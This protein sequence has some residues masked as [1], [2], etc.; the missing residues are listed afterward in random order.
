M[1]AAGGDTPLGRGAEFDLIRAMRERWGE[2]AV[3]IGDD[4]A[5]LRPARGEQLI[6]T[7]DASIENVHFRREWLT[8]EEIGYRAV[9]AALSD[10]A[11]MAAIPSGILIALAITDDTRACIGDIADGIGAAARASGAMILGGNVARSAQFSITTTALG[12]AFTPLTRSGARP[13]DLLYVTGTLGGPAAA[14]RAWKAGVAPAPDV[15]A[16]FARPAARIR[17]ARWLAA[18]GGVAAID[19]SDGLGGDVGH[20]AAASDVTIEV[21]LERVPCWPQATEEDAIGGGEEFELLVL[22][23]APLAEREF[24]E[25]FD[26]PLTLIGRA[27]ESGA[28]VRFTR[29]GKRVAAPTGY[30]HLSR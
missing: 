16:R 4:A 9:T 24:R 30:D 10:L 25:R 11:A 1:S 2:L 13:G 7:T 8:W 12:V 19:I 6:A 22:A 15:R 21:Q 3:G 28:G 5:V 26:L 23:R 20:L 29:D 14:L 18:H 17:E 27:M